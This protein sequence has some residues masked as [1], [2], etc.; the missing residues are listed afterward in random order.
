V[1]E[2]AVSNTAQVGAA[3]TPEE[4]SGAVDGRGGRRR[5][6]LSLGRV[7]DGFLLRRE[8]SVLLVAIGLMIYFQVTDPIFLTRG[9]LVNIAQATAPVAIVAV[10]IVLLLVSGEID[11]SVGI[12]AALAPFLIHFAI[13]FYAVPV[14][15]ALLLALAIA[16][17]IG[18]LNGLIV[19]KLN[20]PSFVTTL[21]TF[22][23]IQGIL[24]I[25]SHA[26]PVPIPDPAK[27]AFQTWLGA[28]PWASITWAL[29]IVAIFHTILTRTRWGLHTVSAR[30]AAWSGSWRPFASTPSIR[31]SAAARR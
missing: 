4:S 29:I 7:L 13:D 23:A 16:A 20:V 6:A 18:L 15:P 25:T 26:Y 5:P 12:V 14:L 3:E 11:L 28:G 2:K 22:F 27:G 1:E 24:L 31:T 10:G 19:T 21:G 17:G 30:S 8:A 9:N